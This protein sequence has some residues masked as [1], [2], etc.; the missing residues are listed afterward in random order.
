MKFYITGSVF[1]CECFE[2]RE[3][4][5]LKW[6]ESWKKIWEMYKILDKYKYIIEW[7]NSKKIIGISIF[8]NIGRII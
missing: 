4:L 6:C 2:S 7:F 3:L 5:F 1:A 8:E